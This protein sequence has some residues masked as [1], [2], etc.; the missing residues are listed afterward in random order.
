[1]SYVD[2]PVILNDVSCSGSPHQNLTD[3]THRGYGRF[4]HCPN[5]A[6][7]ICEGKHFLYTCILYHVW[8]CVNNQCMILGVCEYLV[9]VLVLILCPYKIVHSY[10]S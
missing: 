3:C 1:M 9:I 4:S 6:L 2:G 10:S 8:M 5:I 7:A